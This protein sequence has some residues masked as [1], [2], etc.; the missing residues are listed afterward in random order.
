MMEINEAIKLMKPCA[1][2]GKPGTIH[3]ETVVDNCYVPQCSSKSGCIA[4][5]QLTYSEYYE[6][7]FDTPE[8]ALEAWNSR[9]EEDRLN[10]KILELEAELMDAY[11]KAYYSQYID[12]DD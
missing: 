6:E 2:C 8:E 4:S 5:N 11:D 10:N 3:R 12:V 1:Y 7:N 9:P